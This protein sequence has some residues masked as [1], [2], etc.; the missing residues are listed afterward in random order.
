MVF[1]FTRSELEVSPRSPHQ[2]HT[3]SDQLH[4]VNWKMDTR[5]TSI[6]QTW[7]ILQTWISCRLGVSYRLGYLADLGILQA[8]ISCILGLSCRLGS[9]C[10]LRVSEGGPGSEPK[11]E[12]LGS[13][14]RCGTAATKERSGCS[15]TRF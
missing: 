9:S 14:F 12:V 1:S 11:F 13:W 15:V 5:P 4:T 3:N 8:W 2:L 10:R 6:L 7:G